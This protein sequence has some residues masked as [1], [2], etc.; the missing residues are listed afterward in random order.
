[1]KNDVTG[2]IAGAFDVIHPGYILAFAEAKCHCGT[3]VVCLHK[4]P[5]VERPE[6][7]K[8]V[9]TVGERAEILRSIRFVD[10]VISYQTEHDF[11]EILKEINPDVRFLGEDYDVGIAKITGSELNIPVRF[12]NRSHGWSATKFKKLICKSMEQL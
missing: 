1:M 6:K 8:P 7:P 4:D 10:K 12:L 11:L 3:L 2:L 9:L 5:S